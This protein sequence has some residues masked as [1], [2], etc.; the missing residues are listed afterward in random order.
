MPL[1]SIDRKG[2]LAFLLRLILSAVLFYAA[3][4][5]LRP[6]QPFILTIVE[7]GW[8][9]WDL[10]PTVA[11][12]VIGLEFVFATLLLLG[13]L[14]QSVHR[15]LL[16]FLGLLSLY[17]I[18]LLIREG[19]IADCG[20]MGAAHS[21]TP[22]TSL[23]KNA[24][25]IAALLIIMNLGGGPGIE[26][27]QGAIATGVLLLGLAAPYIA[28]RP[29]SWGKNAGDSTL[30]DY[31]MEQLKEMVEE[32]D[33][34]LELDS[35]KRV[36][37]FV[38]TSCHWCKMATRKLGIMDDRLEKELPLYF[39]MS[40]KEQDRKDFWEETR[41]GPYPS[42][43]LELNELMNYTGGG[44][45]A[46]LLTED[47]KAIAL[48]GFNSIREERMRAFLNEGKEGSQEAR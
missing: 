46:V 32:K 38:S 37:V 28:E 35:G 2:I 31:P 33:A 12:L 5:K 15:S 6:I 14:K 21:I 4:A 45:P 47:G 20:C 42:T 41:A 18:V 36:L 34:D 27:Y 24:G 17:L 25:M 40:G 16:V 48:L 11:R 23:I 7:G 44:F 43:L 13:S 19:N 26:K 8:V 22:L 3:I 30:P 1:A 39:F 9:G 29:A 10:A